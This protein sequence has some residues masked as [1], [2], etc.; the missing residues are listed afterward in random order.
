HPLSQAV[1]LAYA[2]WVRQWRGAR[3]QAWTLTQALATLEREHEFALNVTYAPIE[4]G[5]G[6]MQRGEFT[7]GVMLFTESLAQYRATGSRLLLPYF[8]SFLAEVYGEQG[9][10]QEGLAIIDEALQF[11]ETNFDRF[12]AAEVYRIKGELTLQSQAS[13]NRV[14][15]NPQIPVPGPRPPIPKTKR[16]SAFSKPLR[17]PAS[18]KRS[19]WSCEQR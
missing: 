15:I 16:R 9:K 13:L 8:L 14:E 1:A 5:R 3:H 4:Q 2:G 18:K 7:T 11:T 19:P 10:L 6:L 12:W 17:L